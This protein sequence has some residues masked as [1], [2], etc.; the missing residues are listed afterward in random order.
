MWSAHATDLW[1]VERYGVCEV[2]CL[3]AAVQLSVCM[4]TRARGPGGWCDQSGSHLIL[5]AHASDQSVRSSAYRHHKIMFRRLPAAKYAADFAHHA[6]GVARLNHG[7]F[8]SVPL[9]VVQ[10]EAEHRAHWRANPVHHTC[11]C[12]SFFAALAQRH[13]SLLLICWWHNLHNN[14]NLTHC[15]VLSALA[16]RMVPI[17]R[18]EQ[19][20]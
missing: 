9:P 16:R 1:N 6:A 14:N 20:H 19:P 4:C 8:G 17:L 18:L 13:S 3:Q 11:R 2:G 5:L 15:Q 7:S 10:A 12:R